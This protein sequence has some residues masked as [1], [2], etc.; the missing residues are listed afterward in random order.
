MLRAGDLLALRVDDIV[1]APSTRPS[2]PRSSAGAEGPIDDPR[3]YHRGVWR[4]Q[5]VH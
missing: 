3:I 1:T 4:A 2:M 5:S